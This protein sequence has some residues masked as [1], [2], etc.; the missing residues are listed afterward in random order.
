MKNVLN[1][2]IDIFR[3]YVNVFWEVKIEDA[4]KYLKERNCPIT[5]DDAQALKE[6]STAS[7]GLTSNAG[8]GNRDIMIWLRKKP[9]TIKE[10]G[11]LYHEIYHATYRIAKDMS[12]SSEEELQCYLYEHIVM[13]CLNHLKAK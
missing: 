3:V 11:V 13:K 6:V 4:I 9:V 10:Y 7:D 8:A 5:D 2:Q 1:I 12:A